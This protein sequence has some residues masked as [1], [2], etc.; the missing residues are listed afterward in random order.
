MATEA[1]LKEINQLRLL[2][3]NTSARETIE[4]I[5]EVYP[6]VELV[7]QAVNRMRHHRRS[8]QRDIVDDT[9]ANV[10][11]ALE[12]MHQTNDQENLVTSSARLIEKG[13]VKVRV[14]TRGRVHSEGGIL[15]YPPGQLSP[16][17]G[18][19]FVYEM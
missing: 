4:Q 15:D 16:L 5:S 9:Q 19:D 10:R 8:R 12:L 18:L 14:Y 2:I 7:D 17:T 11:G 6:R 13:R 3:G 1:E